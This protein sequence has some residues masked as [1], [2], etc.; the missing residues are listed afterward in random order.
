[1]CSGSTPVLSH[2]GGYQLAILIYLY[3]MDGQG[4]RFSTRVFNRIPFEGQLHNPVLVRVQH[5]GE[6]IISTE[7]DFGPFDKFSMVPIFWFEECSG[8]F[9][10]GVRVARND[11]KVNQ[12]A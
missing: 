12:I 6:F 7:F 3:V 4:S 8:I 11:D 9:D 10:I 1:M 5:L 2:T